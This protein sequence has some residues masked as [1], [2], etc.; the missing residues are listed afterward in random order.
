MLCA[1]SRH[2][3]MVLGQFV[4]RK[5][6]DKLIDSVRVGGCESRVVHRLWKCITFRA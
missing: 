3:E 1:I 2:V 4:G 6:R 5:L